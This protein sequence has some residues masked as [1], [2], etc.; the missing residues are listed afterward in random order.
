MKQNAK[1]IIL[2]NINCAFVGLHSDDI[3]LLYNKFSYE[4]PNYFFNPR[5][6]M[7]MWDGQNHF[8]QKTGKTYIYLVP[9]ILPILKRLDYKVTL[10][11]RRSE[12][13]IKPTLIDADYF[14]H[15]ENVENGMPWK[16]RPYQVE[17]VNT[18]LTNGSGIAIAGTGAGKSSICAALA[19]SYEKHGGL[20]TITVVPNVNLVTQTRNEF[21]FLGLDTGEFCGESKDIEHAHVI[22]TWQSLKNVPQLLKM[23]QVIIVDE[24]HGVRG[25]V[26]QQLLN[27]HGTHIAHRFGVTGTLPKHPSDALSILVSLGEVHYEIAAHELIDQGWL[28]KLHIEIFR[29][30]VDLTA[31]YD[32]FL[33]G[34]PKIIP[35]Y[36]EFKEQFFPDWQSEKEFLHVEKKRLH[37]IGDYLQRKRSENK[38]NVLCLVDSIKFGRR[39]QEY[40]PDSHFVHGQDKAKARQEIYNLFQDNDNVVVIATVHIAGTGLNIKRIFNLVFV[41][42]GRSFIRVI[43]TIGRGLRKAVDKDFVLVSDI[44]SD[45]KYSR[46]HTRERIS[47][48]KEAGYPYKKTAVDYNKFT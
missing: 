26:L 2:D 23:F 27:K 48:Y 8:F 41:D 9:E 34:K 47:F 33:S 44:C 30:D 13:F 31:E 19:D 28:A 12:D 45:L 17:A 14:S 18:L 4:A 46:R 42:M 38:G 22:S 32:D 11:D 35:S 29:L 20:R 37:W 10:D 6:K 43:Q 25:N 39:L 1:L 3:E 7:G 36:K 24:C 21:S 40:V 15:I 16:M 5:Y